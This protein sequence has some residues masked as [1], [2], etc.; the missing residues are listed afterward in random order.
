MIFAF[1]DDTPRDMWESYKFGAKCA[2]LGAHDSS[3]IPYVPYPGSELYKELKDRGAIAEMSDEYFNSLIP[4]SDLE[5]AKSY[6]PYLSDRQLIWLRFAYFGLFY[7]IMYLRRPYR[8]FRI[9]YK[10][11]EKQVSRGEEILRTIIKRRR[12]LKN[13]PA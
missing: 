5:H 11:G 2:W 13:L 8:L 10:S 7:G 4:F 6:N 1:P 12:Q 9:F 3:F